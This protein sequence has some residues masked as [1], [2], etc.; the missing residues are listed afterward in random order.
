[1]ISGLIKLY[2]KN[3]ITSQDIEGTSFLLKS[4]TILISS[5]MDE[6]DLK[7]LSIGVC[8]YKF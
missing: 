5:R 6:K 3:S 4:E 8:K 2:P 1:M 7:P